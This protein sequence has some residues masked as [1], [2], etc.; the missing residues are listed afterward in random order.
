MWHKQEALVG[1]GGWWGGRLDSPFSSLC[2][3]PSPQPERQH[4]DLRH[5]ED[6]QK[7]EVSPG[8]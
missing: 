6:L 3:A 4:T 7:Y 1:R 5:L 8:E 2:T